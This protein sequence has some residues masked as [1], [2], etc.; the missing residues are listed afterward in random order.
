[1]TALDILALAAY[2]LLGIALGLVHFRSL[3]ATI[4][5]WREDGGARR[6]A[7][8]H[9]LRWAGLGL[10]LWAVAIQGGG[11]LLAAA[12]GILLA[13]PLALRQ[14]GGFGP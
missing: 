1:M 12:A 2:G 3:A 11:P 5:L 8:L 14:T 6:A 4:R 13:R 10:A 7:A 9:G